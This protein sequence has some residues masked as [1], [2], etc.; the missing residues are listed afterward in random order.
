M[1]VLSPAVRVLCRTELRTVLRDRRAVLMSIVL[2]LI[3]MPVVLVSSQWAEQRRARQLTEGSVRFAVAGQHRDV[4]RDLVAEA[5]GLPP[6][7]GSSVEP[8]VTL[9]EDAS[10]AD[11]FAALQGGDVDLVV[12]SEPRATQPPETDPPP[13]NTPPVRIVYRSDRDRSRLAADWLAARLDRLR[14]VRQIELLGRSGVVVQ[15]RAAAPAHSEDLAPTARSAGLGLGRVATLLLVFFLFS[16]GALVAQ[17]TL[18]GEKERGTLE[19]LL[20]TS[21]TRQDIVLA[22][23]LLVVLVALVITAI[24]VANLLVYAGLHIVPA[25]TSLSTAVSPA[26]AAGLLIFLLPLAAFVAGILVLLSGYSRSHREA[27]LYFLPVLLVA[28]LP[29]SAA[30]L[31][32]ASLRSL[33]VLVPIANISV[34]VKD[35]L[36]GRIDWPMLVGAW[37]VNA[38]AAALTLRAAART[39]T[40]ER[41]IVPATERRARVPGAPVRPGQLATWFAAMWGVIFLVSS[42]LGA[43]FD[44]RGQLFVNLVV[45]FFGGS[46]LFIRF[47]RLSPRDVLAL[48][49]PSTWTWLGVLA[50]APAGLVTGLG[51]FRL[52]QLVVPVPPDMLKSFAQYLA[53]DTLPMWQILPLMTVLP[54]ICEEVAF[55]G[56]LLH[57]LR[58]HFSRTVTALLVG[59]TFGLFHFSVFRIAQTAYLG[60]LLALVTMWSGSIFP[61]MLWHAASNGLA[62]AAG[63]GG[64]EL[65]HLPPVAYAFAATVLAAALWLIRRTG[66]L[67]SARAGT[68]LVVVTLACGLH[69]ASARAQPSLAEGRT[70]LAKGDPRRAITAADA[71]LAKSPL[72]ADALALKLEALAS[73]SDW[74]T[75]LDAY[76]RFLDAGGREDAEML[77]LIGTASLREVI[78]FFPTVRQLAQARLACGGDRAALLELRRSPVLRPD[79]VDGMVAR[80]QLGDVAVGST[81]RELA[82]EGA[83]ATRAAALQGLAQLQDRGAD[84]AV[85]AGLRHADPNVRL[86]AVRLARVTSMGGVESEVQTLLTDPVGLVVAEATAALAVMGDQRALAQLPVLAA[87]P[88]P[89]VRLA[90]LAAQLQREATPA[91]LRAL[92]TVAR[93]RSSG[94]W[95]AAVDLLIDADPV[96][97]AS[98]LREALADDNPSIRIQA[99]RLASKVPMNEQG[100]LARFR[101]LLRDPNTFVRLEASAVLATRSRLCGS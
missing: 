81:L 2:P 16:G 14:H 34:G 61:A 9:L 13:Q 36:V 51:L 58:P 57:G 18:A 84:E 48:R 97:A 39:L 99:L 62:L 30:F 31:P 7:Q 35:V 80:A 85:R 77:R 68:L 21:M 46:L 79:D 53:P 96:S 22:K 24:Q 65:G 26:L 89:D 67:P 69:P 101:E 33:L 66:R 10:L 15:S 38:A 60:V 19:T 41:L 6:T 73:A 3:V 37:A 100:D 59:L 94:A 86:A 88:I 54:G 52:S 25:A 50:G 17:D 4:L 27:Q 74:E 5:G 64:I 11:P 83:P 78:A 82:S 87:S 28:L 75:G 70:A 95:T 55:R 23:V 90:A 44:I 71:V 93:L 76:E 12:D 20:T 1:N 8:M 42:N 56:V 45:V 43:E 63:R 32:A 98:A 40:A 29:A 49:A 91:T 47:F 72:A 92:T